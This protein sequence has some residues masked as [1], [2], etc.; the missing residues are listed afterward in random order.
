MD[1]QTTTLNPNSEPSALMKTKKRSTTCAITP[2]ARKKTF[3]TEPLKILYLGFSSK[4]LRTKVLGGSSVV[5]SGVISPLTWV[6][7]IVTLL[8]T[9]LMTTYE[10]PSRA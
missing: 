2:G 4:N 7:S 8:I 3:V 10:P 1:P 9:L 5:I 6:I